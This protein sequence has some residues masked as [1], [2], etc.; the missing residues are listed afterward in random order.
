MDAEKIEYIRPDLTEEEQVKLA[1]VARR[2]FGKPRSQQIITI[3][4]LLAENAM[5]TREVNEHRTARG[6]EPLPTY[7]PK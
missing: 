4:L 5:L 7:D 1:L 3:S 2:F 6:Y